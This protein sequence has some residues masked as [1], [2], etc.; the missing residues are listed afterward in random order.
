MIV[1]YSQLLTAFGLILLANSASSGPDWLSISRGDVSSCDRMPGVYVHE[2][3][4]Y[5]PEEV[6]L[7][8]GTVCGAF[9]QGWFVGPVSAA[10]MKRVLPGEGGAS[11]LYQA[12][13]DG[14]AKDYRKMIGVGTVDEEL[15]FEFQGEAYHVNIIDP[16]FMSGGKPAHSQGNGF[17]YDGSLPTLSELR[18][19]RWYFS[20]A[21]HSLAPSHQAVTIRN[22]GFGALPMLAELGD[23]GFVVVTP[24]AN[25]ERVELSLELDGGNITGGYSFGQTN[26]L[27]KEVRDADDYDHASVEITD[28]IGRAVETENGGLVMAVGT[29]TVTLVGATGETSTEAASFYMTGARLPDDISQEQINYLFED[30]MLEF[31][32]SGVEMDVPPGFNL[33]GAFSD[34]VPSWND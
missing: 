7:V 26:M 30:Q 25:M 15:P 31:D 34:G 23:D 14:V 20:P 29:G 27:L 2:T 13:E 11:G 28:M 5:S 21:V 24:T 10:A 9:D 22:G 3:K 8:M 4:T 1:R 17:L 32:E 18:P 12:F 19:G 16:A 6:R 33:E